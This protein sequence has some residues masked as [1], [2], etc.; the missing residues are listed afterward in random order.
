MSPR[1]PVQKRSRERFEQILLTSGDLLAKT[2]NADDLTT[3]TVSKRSGVPVATIY[4]YFADR[5]AII[6]TLIDR[7]MAEI[8]D[9]IAAELER[10]DTISIEILLRTIMLTHLNH[11]Q[12]NRRAIVLWFGARESSPVLARVEHRYAYMGDWVQN[13]STAAGFVVAEAPEW[14]GELIVWMSD[15]I[16]E[17]MFRKERSAEQQDEL[18]E[19]FLEMMTAQILKY[20]TPS[21]V[22]G[23][24]G[25]EFR[26]KA[27]A[28]APTH[29][30]STG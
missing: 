21:G 7:E 11:F 22:D 14:G 29:L 10:L 3:T 19:E 4:R 15:R 23:I 25:A 2:G 12:Q 8:D 9:E 24:P 27:G 6:A 20:A 17:I 5:I 30:D 16:F 26:A 13:G 1:T 18:F 28:W